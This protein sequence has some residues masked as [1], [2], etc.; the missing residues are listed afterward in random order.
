MGERGPAGTGSEPVLPGAVFCPAESAWLPT[1]GTWVRVNAISTGPAAVGSPQ[2]LHLTW[3][4]A[5]GRWYLIVPIIF[6]TRN[7]F[8]P[9]PG[10]HV[11]DRGVEAHPLVAHVATQR[12][13]PAPGLGP[14]NGGA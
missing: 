10:V 13:P 9:T 8:S 1:P 7:Y 5:A 4:T 3:W 12:G 14:R 2:R 6:N 11:C